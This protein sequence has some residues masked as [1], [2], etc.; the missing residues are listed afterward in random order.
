LSMV[1]ADD[2]VLRLS[3]PIFDG[4]YEFFRRELLLGREPS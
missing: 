2:E 3:G 4:L 1:R